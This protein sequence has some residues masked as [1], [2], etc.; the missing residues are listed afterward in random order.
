MMGE[1]KGESGSGSELGAGSEYNVM[2][3]NPRDNPGS[4]PFSV[5][6]GRGTTV[7]SLKQR[8][9]SEYPGSPSVHLQRLIYAGKLLNNDDTVSSIFPSPGAHT[10]HLVVSRDQ[11]QRSSTP[12]SSSGGRVTDRVPI[13]TGGRDGRGANSAS[14]GG[15]A[16]NANAS[17][18]TGAPGGSI[19]T[20]EPFVIPNLNGANPY[21]MGPPPFSQ[22][23]PMYQP[24]L[25][26]AH[27]QAMERAFAEV[28]EAQQVFRNAQQVARSS[29]TDTANYVRAV[30]EAVARYE[31]ALNNNVN[32]NN[33]NNNNNNNDINNA[34]PGAPLFAQQNGAPRNTFGVG[35]GFQ[36]GNLNENG[37]F[38]PHDPNN[39]QHPLHHLANMQQ[40][41]APGQAQAQQQQQQPFAPFNIHHPFGQVPPLNIRIP[42]NAPGAAA[43][44]QHQP[45]VR[46]F[47][48]QFDLNWSL[49]LKLAL[50]VFILAQDA[51]PRRVQTLG[52]LA[53]VVYLWQTGQLTFVRRMIGMVLPTP[54]QLFAAMGINSAQRN[55]ARE[56]NV[57]SGQQSQQQQQAEQQQ[58]RC[59]KVTVILSYVYSFFYGFV[60]SLLPAWNPEPL[61]NINDLLNENPQ[62]DGNQRQG[63]RNADAAVNQRRDQVEL[64]EHAE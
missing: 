41:G 40:G 37:E 29:E 39:A 5:N 38:Q 15:A 20:Q 50:L 60:C 13:G 6:V 10:V 21:F 61:P 43:G 42:Q 30:N 51:S 36:V 58:R 3:K 11:Q 35:F 27:I 4:S 7:L 47:V 56:N 34:H 25:Y 33:N 28:I 55:E 19:P 16:S 54:R 9:Q 57:Q 26:A 17:P 59:S 62:Q 31:A 1:E 14:T 49:L 2:V 53:V 64:H 12:N 46:Q 63:A 45:R 24:A 48:F 18:S 44:G 32:S 22:Q 52:F 23:H 8:L